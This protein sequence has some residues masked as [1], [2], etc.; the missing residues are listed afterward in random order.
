M[1]NKYLGA[2]DTSLQVQLG[3]VLGALV[4]DLPLSSF[5]PFVG[6]LRLRPGAENK[7]DQDSVES[8][9]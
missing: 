3:S 8:K 1:N 2:N 9:P 5:Q 7:M 6:D 4:S